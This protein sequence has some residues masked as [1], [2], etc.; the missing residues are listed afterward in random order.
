VIGI[1]TWVLDIPSNAASDFPDPPIK[2]PKKKMQKDLAQ[3]ILEK[4]P[5]E[6]TAD[7]FRLVDELSLFMG[8]SAGKGL[9]ILKGYAGTGKTAIISSLVRVLSESGHD[10]VLLAPTGR[11]AKVMAAYT[12]MPAFTIHKKIYRLQEGREG[13]PLVALQA[14]RHRD[15]LFIVDEASMIGGA[16]EAASSHL[17]G[18]INLLD[19]LVQYVYG[20]RGCRMILIGDT[21][22]LPPVSAPEIPALK[23]GYMEK[24]FGLR[25]FQFELQ[26]VVRQARES[27][28]LVNATRLRQMLA[29][30]REGFPA[31]QREGFGDFISLDAE[32]VLDEIN[33]AFMGRKIQ[34]A[35]VICRSNK[36]A[37]L[38][39]QNIRQR[40]LFQEDEINSGDLLMVVKNN[41][42]WLPGE[43][44][45][46]FIANGDILE[47]NR[48]RK[49]EDI[50][51]FRFADIEASFCDYP[52][53][54]PVEMKVMLSTLDLHGPSLGH[55]DQ[56]RLF[57]A[58]SMD[59][60]DITNK[61]KRLAAIRNNPYFNALQVKFAYALTCHKAQGGQW[62]KVFIDMGYIP[63]KEPDTEY[64]RWLYTAVTRATKK[65]F[66]LNF[67]PEFFEKQAGN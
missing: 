19:D 44:M 29:A 50:Y 55:A 52:E 64:L 23:A 43:S 48:I 31:F 65:V 1:L 47:V 38:F 37:W 46:G 3:R 25:V 6:S 13:T 41:Y 8:D 51:G 58:I 49:T 24:Q 16:A 59:Y 12:G 53:E 27:G 30:G 9:F 10:T 22:Q 32:T 62:E 14:N 56:K 17:F 57:E 26:E 18:G 20:G 67:K 5:Y 2:S 35:L 28:I 39:N 42:Y 7:Q 33:S 54:P 11:A 63:K 4:F 36:R 40:V 34:E 45:A 66:L 15:T 60:Q 21:A 61:R